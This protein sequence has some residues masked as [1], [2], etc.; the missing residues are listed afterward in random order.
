MLHKIYVPTQK[1]ILH[2]GNSY[3]VLVFTF[4]CLLVFGVY[5]SLD[6]DY[7][8]IGAEYSKTITVFLFGSGFLVQTIS[9]MKLVLSMHW[10]FVWP[11]RASRFISIIFDDNQC[12]PNVLTNFS[13]KCIF[14]KKNCIFILHFISWIF[15]CRWL[16]FSSRNVYK[17]NVQRLVQ[18]IK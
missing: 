11:P 7:Y 5:L 4:W 16:L 1:Y 13:L 6:F 14:P 9:F 15:K 8:S 3:D 18:S 10:N 12:H 17:F 2:C